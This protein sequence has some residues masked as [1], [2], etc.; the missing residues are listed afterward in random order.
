VLFCRFFSALS[1]PLLDCKYGEYWFSLS[2]LSMMVIGSI[3]SYTKT[4]SVESAVWCL[5]TRDDDV[6]NRYFL[7]NGIEIPE[8][9]SGS[10]LHFWTTIKQA[11]NQWEMKTTSNRTVNKINERSITN[12]EHKFIQL[13]ISRVPLFTETSLN[14]TF[15]ILHRVKISLWL[16]N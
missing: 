8:H 15:L 3:A 9:S 10:E 1:C 7:Y 6:E 12:K 5:L 4:K 13:N 2:R 16:R 11:K 14:V